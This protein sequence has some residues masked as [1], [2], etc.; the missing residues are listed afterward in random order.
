MKKLIKLTINDKV[1]KPSAATKKPIADEGVKLGLV[2]GAGVYKRVPCGA[3]EYCQ[4]ARLS[5]IKTPMPN[6][7]INLFDICP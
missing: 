2:P 6:M 5:A 4:R 3:N 1:H 7:S